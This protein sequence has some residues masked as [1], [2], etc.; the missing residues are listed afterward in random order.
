MLDL[1]FH[2][3]CVCGTGIW[4]HQGRHHRRNEAG[5]EGREGICNQSHS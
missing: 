4:K 3:I 1:Y 5:F 2:F